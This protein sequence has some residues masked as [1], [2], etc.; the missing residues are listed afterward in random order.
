[1]MA[2]RPIGEAMAVRNLREIARLVRD[3]LIQPSASV[4]LTETVSP[5]GCGMFG[6]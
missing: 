2:A 5:I 4:S 1:M 6:R 3:E